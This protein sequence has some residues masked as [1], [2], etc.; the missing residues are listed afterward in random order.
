MQYL[1]KRLF[2]VIA[3]VTI[4]SGCQKYEDI[5]LVLGADVNAGEVLSAADSHG[6]FH[7]DGERYMEFQFDGNAFEDVIK[8]D[9]TWHALPVKE[10]TVQ[11]MFYGLEKDGV[12]YGPYINAELPDV[13]EGYYFIYDRHSESTE[14]FD[15]TEILERASLNFTAA[16]YDANTDRLYYVEVD[17]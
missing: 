5:S 15:S 16:I 6:G 7:G 14:P 9:N 17:T 11:A 13:E 1:T 8:K 10:D 4:L 12:V 3:A 2:A